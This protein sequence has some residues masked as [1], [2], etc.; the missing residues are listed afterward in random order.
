MAVEVPGDIRAGTADGALPPVAAS[1]PS[2]P[3]AALSRALAVPLVV[4]LVGFLPAYVTAQ[5]GTGV[6]DAAYWLQLTLTVYAGGRL[7][8]MVLTRRR[9]LIQGA[10]WL[11]VY[12]AMGVAPLAQDVIGQVPTP[13]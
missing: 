13:V 2:V 8:A 10:F 7:S 5:P 3:R 11:F 6:R 4:A 12:V 9:R 1:G